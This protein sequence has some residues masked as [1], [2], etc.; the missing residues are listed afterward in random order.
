LINKRIIVY[1]SIN[2]QYGE[3]FLIIFGEL[4]KL[5]ASTSEIRE[6]AFLVLYV[7]YINNFINKIKFSICC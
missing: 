5:A 6:Q 4:Q 2:A 1:V 7:E 3:N